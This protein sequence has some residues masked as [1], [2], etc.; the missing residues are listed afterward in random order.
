MR[1]QTKGIAVSR[2][3]R[4]VPSH[5]SKI[6]AAGLGDTLK[7][8]RGTDKDKIKDCAHVSGLSEG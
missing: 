5:L 8:G 1:H 6:K 4:R 2:E 7:I 3:I